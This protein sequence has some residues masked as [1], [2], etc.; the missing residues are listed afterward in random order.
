[1]ISVSLVNSAGSLTKS[2]LSEGSTVNDLFQVQDVDS[3]GMQIKINGTVVSLDH[4]LQEGDV[5]MIAEETK[6]NADF[7]KISE[8]IQSRLTS[9]NANYRLMRNLVA[10][11]NAAYIDSVNF[12]AELER[13]KTV[14]INATKHERTWAILDAQHAVS[15]CRSSVGFSAQE[16]DAKVSALNALQ[17]ENT[18]E[19]FQAE[20]EE[21]NRRIEVQREQL[22]QFDMNIDFDISSLNKAKEEEA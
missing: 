22:G 14:L 15:E 16:L 1:M 7:P 11:N 10:A 13:Q 21:L 6:G 2:S 9:K 8:Y 3:E 20:V 19:S 12:M 18:E 17:A 4:V 5:V